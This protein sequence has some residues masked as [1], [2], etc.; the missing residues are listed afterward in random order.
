MNKSKYLTQTMEKALIRKYGDGRKIA[1]ALNIT[2][3]MWRY[4][5]KGERELSPRVRLII[6]YRLNKK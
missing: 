4:L 1:T 6:E 5:V 2:Y 3:R